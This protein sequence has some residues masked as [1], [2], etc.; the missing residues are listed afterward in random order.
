V[1]GEV[2]VSNVLD[3]NM[4][5][6]L[7]AGTF[8]MI[9]PDTENGV[10]RAPTKVGLDS[11]GAAL[12]EFKALPEK[13]Q[14]NSPVT[15]EAP[16]R[17]IASVEADKP[18]PVKGQII[19]MT[20]GKVGQR[21]P[22]SATTGAHAYLKKKMKTKNVQL[23]SA[24]IQFYGLTA[25]T[26]IEPKDSPRTPASL[27]KAPV[28]ELPKKI[29][30]EVHMDAEFSESLRLNQGSQPKHSKELENLIQDLQSY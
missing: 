27:M 1:N 9:D 13:L 12:A 24:P 11:L 8:T 19:F 21:N 26:L 28:T 20:N 22:A 2:E 10:P 23:T 29:A 18:A 3:K 15:T 4:K 7:S 25:P 5:Y 14:E 6:T 16:T 30:T 17:S